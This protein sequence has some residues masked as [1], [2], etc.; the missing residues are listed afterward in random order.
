MYEKIVR[1]F[2]KFLLK[3]KG[4]LPIVQFFEIQS[5]DVLRSRYYADEILISKF[6]ED[7]T[8]EVI[9]GPFKG[10]RYPYQKSVGSGLIT[11]LIGTYESELHNVI[12]KICQNSYN[13]ILN[14]GAGE[15]F[16]AVGLAMRN[17][18]SRIFAFETD[19]TGQDFCKEM[20]NINKINDNLEI[21]G[22][23]NTSDLKNFIEN[24]SPG[25]ILMDCEGCEL[26]LLDI[27]KLPNLRTFDILVE[28]HDFSSSGPT[29][30]ESFPSRFVETHEITIINERHNKPTTHLNNFSLTPLQKN[31]IFNEGRKYSVG[32]MFLKSKKKI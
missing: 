19:K 14:I 22:N 2:L 20:A 30:M 23:C 4:G 11:K 17:P 21:L 7:E 5:K 24:T 26:E 12:E 18:K 10:L 8:L 25:L 31:N 27:N 9:H 15:G 1:L 13:S 16:Y 28:L 3:F 6:F 32:W 29:I